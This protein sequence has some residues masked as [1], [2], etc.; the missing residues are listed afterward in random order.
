[1]NKRVYFLK[2]ESINA[3][4]VDDSIIAHCSRI[5]VAR[6]CKCITDFI[7]YWP[8]G[9]PDVSLMIWSTLSLHSRSYSN[10]PFVSNFVVVYTIPNP[11]SCISTKN[12]ILALLGDTVLCVS[13]DHAAALHAF[14]Y[15]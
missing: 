12:T 9:K 5:V 6:L 2:V 1:M 8:S 10:F 13:S 11:D 3:V 4:S 7:R 14:Q 15:R